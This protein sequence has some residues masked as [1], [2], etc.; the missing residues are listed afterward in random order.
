M[1]ISIVKINDININ[2]IVLSNAKKYDKELII[3]IAYNKV[4]LLIELPKCFCEKFNNNTLDLELPDEIANI[5]NNIDEHILKLLKNY[6]MNLINL[7]QYKSFDFSNTDFKN[8]VINNVLKIKLIHNKHFNTKVFDSDKNI[9]NTERL[10]NTSIGTENY[11]LI[12]NNTNYLKTILEIKAVIFKKNTL[13]LY[14]IT[15]QV[16]LCN[17][18]IKKIS[19]DKY[20]F[21]DSDSDKSNDSDNFDLDINSE[22]EALHE[23]RKLTNV[24]PEAFEIKKMEEPIQKNINQNLGVNNN[25][26][27]VSKHLENNTNSKS[28]SDEEASLPINKIEKNEVQMVK[29]EALSQTSIIKEEET[30]SALPTFNNKNNI[31]SETSYT[32]DKIIIGTNSNVSSKNSAN[33]NESPKLNSNIKNKIETS[34]SSSISSTKMS[35]QSNIDKK[36]DNYDITS[37]DNKVNKLINN[38]YQ[39]NSE[40]QKYML[41]KENSKIS[42]NNFM[43]K[44]L[45]SAKE[46][47]Y[48]INTNDVQEK[49]D[50][51]LTNVSITENKI[52][53][54]ET[55]NIIDQ[56]KLMELNNITTEHA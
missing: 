54:S 23:K 25:N 31:V 41:V 51:F 50:D 21:L 13:F 28:N 15:H 56:Q 3:P 42:D 10:A 24:P 14:I 49:R 27:A 12:F 38:V 1:S 20:S 43:N 2:K 9:I 34:E 37:V 40:K 47:N 44:L 36:Q 17:S 53:D 7:P 39:T 55:D 33:S 48:K 32:Q 5:F 6:L 16:A 52:E 19:L 45:N 30:I 35:L 29:E 4:S 26:F 8:T 18:K 11:N 46:S 22:S